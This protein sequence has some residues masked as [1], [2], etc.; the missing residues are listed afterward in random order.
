[1]KKI[2]AAVAIL[3]G[4]AGV[5]A[6]CPAWQNGGF[7]SF[8]TTGSDLYLP[9]NYNVVA[10]GNVSLRNCNWNHTGFLT[11]PST[12]Q[13]RID[14][15]EQYG[16]IQFRA[17]S[18]CDTVLFIYDSRGE[19]WFDDDGLGNFNP[20]LTMLNPA[21]GIYNVWV[22]TYGGG[23]CNAQLQVETWR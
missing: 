7:S 23:T 17:V 3:L 19:P 15:L 4:T 6:A 2:L 16:R 5:A 20:E 9:N 13:F 22:G 1:M 14:G 8:Y 18:N 10:G 12:V 11:S 21:S